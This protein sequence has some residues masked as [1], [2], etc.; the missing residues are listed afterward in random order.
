MKRGERR[1]RAG[2]KQLA[3]SKHCAAV[4]TS[5]SSAAK[6]ASSSAIVSLQQTVTRR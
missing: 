5:G 6:R 3:S 1:V 2:A 4:H